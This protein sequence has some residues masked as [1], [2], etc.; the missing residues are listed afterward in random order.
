MT[1]RVAKTL[2][3]VADSR[4]GILFLCALFTVVMIHNGVFPLGALLYTRGIAGGDSAQMVWNLWHV[5]E[6]I[7]G[8]HNPYFTD[9]IFY[10]VGANL[11]HHTLAAGFFPLTFLVK[12]LSGGDPLY[13][14]YAYRLVVLLCFTLSLYFSFL[15][16]REAGNS[17]WAAATA[18]VGYSFSHFYLLHLMHMNHLAGFFI[19][20]TALLAVRAYR[21]PRKNLTLLAL[22]AALSVYF[23]EFALYIYMAAALFVLA[24]ILYSTER[25]TLFGR[26]RQTGALKLSL[27]AGVF[28]LVAA[29]FV[30]NLARDKVLKPSLA[31][32]SNWSGNLAGFLIP[33]PSR[34][35]VYG[36]IFSALNQRVTVGVGGYEIFLGFAITL[37]AIVAL[38]TVR[39]RYVR[40]SAVLAVVFLVLSL[41]P[42]LKIFGMETHVPMPYALLMR[43]PP[44]DASRTPVRFIVMAL[45]FLMI[46]AASGMTWLQDTLAARRSVRWSYAVMAFIFL[47]SVAEVY[48]P[49]ARQQLFTPPR[50]LERIVPGAVLELP[51]LASDGYASLLQVFHH[52]PIATGYLARNTQAQREQTIALKLLTDRGGRGLCDEL[53]NRGFQ[54]IVITPNE[55]LEPFD[56]GGISDLEL[57]K[58]S[59]PVIDLRVQGVPLAAHPNFVI[60][61]AREEPVEFPLLAAHSRLNF[62]S[63]AAD[64]YL[65][66]GWSGREIFSHW[67]DRGKAALVFSLPP[68]GNDRED[69]IKQPQQVKLR[70]FGA[71]F[72]APGKLDAQRVIV[73]LNDTPLVEWT[74]TSAEPTEHTIEIPASIL[75]E[76]NTLV[77]RLPNAASP[78]SLGVSEDWRLLGFNVQWIEID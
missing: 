55:F 1:K 54:N 38:F 76:G 30:I 72:L 20:L 77:F 11:A 18:A 8:G 41:G 29:P 46:A 12:H 6:S 32:S 66:Y 26:M 10:P 48:Q 37:F 33:D 47:W 16:L 74:L 57:V 21:A 4:L 69:Q 60:R 62:S 44:F 14:V 50:E 27:A 51:L 9:Q 5:N 25:R 70:V 78:I 59:L 28:V 23:T 19:P 73:E 31:Q 68:A 34:T 63:E 52:Q 61:Q 36:H 58:C 7:S 35:H 39:N 22:V 13:P 49:I 17:R 65:W 2:A 42:T 71:P 40:I 43:V 56:Y 75:R 64:K 53:K 67:T 15:L 45:F 3:Q 24:L